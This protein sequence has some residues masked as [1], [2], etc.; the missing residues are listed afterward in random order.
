MPDVLAGLERAWAVT[1]T[2]ALP[3]GTASFVAR[4][5]T[6]DG[7]HAVVKVA[8]PGTGFALQ[9][10]TLTAAAG[11]G[12]VRLLAHA[13]EHDAALLEALGP[14]L[15]ATDLPPGAQ[16]GVLARCL[17]RAWR[18]PPHAGQQP[19][20]KAAELA[21]LVGELWHRLRPPVPRPVLEHALDCAAGRSAAFAP[22]VDAGAC[23]VV[24][25]DAATANAARVLAPRPG[26]VDG[27][28][29]LD[30]DGFLGDPAYDPGVALRDGCRALLAAADPV[31]LL[32]GRC[33]L[34]AAETALDPVAIWEWGFLERM[35]TGLHAL[36]LGA[37]DD[38]A[39]HLRSARRLLPGRPPSS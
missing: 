30:P 25:G 34:L 23:V 5:R 27:V 13:P 7:G 17:R 24:H 26:A 21:A 33:R 29:L 8:V 19:T 22:L 6:A 10:R 36:A 18:V 3:G 12:Y 32:A 37:D 38:G 39:A 4:A 15:P 28:V 1:V 31:A 16:L 9:A 11:D 14:S 20:D 35:S 2:E